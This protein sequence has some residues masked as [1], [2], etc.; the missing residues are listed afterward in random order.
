VLHGSILCCICLLLQRVSC[1]SPFTLMGF[2]RLQN[3]SFNALGFIRSDAYCK[4][5]GRGNASS[6]PISPLRIPRKGFLTLLVN[7]SKTRSA[8]LG[9]TFCRKRDVG[10]HSVWNGLPLLVDKATMLQLCTGEALQRFSSISFHRVSCSIRSP[11]SGW[12][13]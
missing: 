4:V 3:R 2:P 8:G 6:S 13:L 10:G 1:W 9:A 7:A 12:S 5:M 11:C